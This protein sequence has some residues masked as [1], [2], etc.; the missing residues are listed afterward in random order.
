M[1]DIQSLREEINQIDAQIT[2]AFIRRMNT[3]L[4]VAK[5]KLENGLPVYDPD[6][7]Q[8]V[9]AKALAQCPPELTMYAERLYHTLFDVSRSYQRRFFVRET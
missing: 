1:P 5:Y 9:V 8:E 4:E 2:D 7:E 6:R 3:A